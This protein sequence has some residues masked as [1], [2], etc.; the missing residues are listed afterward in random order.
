MHVLWGRLTKLQYCFF[1]ILSKMKKKL[2][3]ITYTVNVNVTVQVNYNNAIIIIERFPKLVYRCYF[4][5][6]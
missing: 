3:E 6:P 4:S 5:W 1:V 2:I